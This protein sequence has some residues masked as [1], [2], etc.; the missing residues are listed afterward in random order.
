MHVRVL[1]NYFK[2][3]HFHF[4]EC[5]KLCN[6]DVPCQ[7]GAKEAEKQVFVAVSVDAES[8][9]PGLDLVHMSV[10]HEQ[11][12]PDKRLSHTKYYIIS[13]HKGNVKLN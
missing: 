3:S 2:E 8:N 5:I 7:S 12:R 4:R 11:I 13:N 9:E 6:K 1:M 10:S